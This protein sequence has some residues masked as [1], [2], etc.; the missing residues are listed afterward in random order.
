FG[1]K[2][3]IGLDATPQRYVAVIQ[4]LKKNDTILRLYSS[5]GDHKIMMECW[6]EDFEKLNDFQEQ[7]EKINGVMDICPTIITDLIK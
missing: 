4:N 6:F 1:V 7:L 3:L 5:T 2:A